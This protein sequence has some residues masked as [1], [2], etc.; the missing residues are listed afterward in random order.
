MIPAIEDR[1]SSMERALQEAILPAL[2]ADQS[3]AIEQAHLLLAQIGLLREQIDFAPDFE[4]QE[5]AGLAALGS[6]LAGSAEGGPRTRVA[7]DK[8]S[9]LLGE[10]A[11]SRPAD[12]RARIVAISRAI[13]DLVEASGLDGSEAFVAQSAD[14]IIAHTAVATRRDRA[15]FR[16]T[17]FER[18]EVKLPSIREV[19]NV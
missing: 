1:L 16:S 9:T 8:L 4:R 3:L 19:L 6:T 12:L 17:G 15:W 7:A 13:E 14:A 11:A 18:G 5:H 2:P 10:N